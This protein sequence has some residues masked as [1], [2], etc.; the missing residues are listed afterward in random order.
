MK[1]IGDYFIDDQTITEEDLEYFLDRR[2]GGAVSGNIEIN[3]AF[4]CGNAVSAL[5]SNAV[6]TGD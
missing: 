2:D 5:G 3:G 1:P 4:S 6:A